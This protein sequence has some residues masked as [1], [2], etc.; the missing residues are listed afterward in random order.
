MEFCHRPKPGDKWHSDEVF[1]PIRGSFGETYRRDTAIAS[2]QID[3]S[4]FTR[5]TAASVPQF[6]PP[7]A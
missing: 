2:Y 5:V 6:S 7:A 4:S 1:A 3:A